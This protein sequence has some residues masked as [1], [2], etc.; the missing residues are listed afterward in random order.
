MDTQ[1]IIFILL[2]IN[3]IM[4]EKAKKLWNNYGF[5]IILVLSVIFI[6]VMIYWRWGKNGTWSTGIEIPE[7]REQSRSIPKISK[8]ERKCRE[9]LEKIFSKPFEKTRPDLLRNPIGTDANMELDCYNNDLKIAV[10]YNGIQHYKYTPY[11]HKTKDA[12]HNQKYRDYIKRQI[13]KDNGILLIEVPYTVKSEDIEEFL[14]GKLRS[15]G[16]FLG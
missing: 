13:C 11:F 6:L 16:V 10:E 8:G 12:F 2:I 5:E 7:F 4:L 9:V 14:V 3:T 15:S 1:E